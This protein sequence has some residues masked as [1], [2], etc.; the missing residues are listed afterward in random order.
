VGQESWVSAHRHI[1]NFL[2]FQEYNFTL[3]TLYY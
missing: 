2:I 1:I 3:I